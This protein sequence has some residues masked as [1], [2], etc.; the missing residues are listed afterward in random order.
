MEATESM[1]GTGRLSTDL[2]G[3]GRRR[4]SATGRRRRFEVTWVL[5]VLGFV[6]IRFLL[7]YSA[8][9][10]ES[11]STVIIFGV[12][13]LVTAVPYA[14]GTARVVTGLIDKDP[15]G[16]AR[17]GALASGSFLAPY[18]WVAWAGRDGSFPVAVYVA[19]ALFAISLGANAIMSVRRRVSAGIDDAG[20]VLG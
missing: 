3:G 18:L 1:K 2:D 13:D 8:L 15:L 11:H 7:V 6:I 20:P 16:A 4:K 5:G 19:T 12:L 9:S 14:V 10:D 17:W